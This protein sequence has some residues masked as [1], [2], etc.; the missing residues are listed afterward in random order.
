MNFYKYSKFYIELPMKLQ[1]C[2]IHVDS[3]K[4]IVNKVKD[5]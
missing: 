2:Y 1:R 3:Q 4:N 5:K